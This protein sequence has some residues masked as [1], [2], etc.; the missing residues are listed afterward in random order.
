MPRLTVRM[1]ARIQGF[2]ADW[3]FTGG[4]T[5][6]YRQVGNAFPPPVARAVGLSIS[7]MMAT[8]TVHPPAGSN[9]VIVF[10]GH[11]GWNL[12]LF[13]VL[14]GVLILVCIPWVY[15]NAVRK[16]PYPHYW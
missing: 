6:S 8:R 12:F 1:V 3:I 10:L 9:P 14:T 5:A 2:A 15:N 7:A 11:S 4:K 13:P 16:T